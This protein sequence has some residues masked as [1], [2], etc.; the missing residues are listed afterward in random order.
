MILNFSLT[1]NWGMIID[2][3]EEKDMLNVIIKTVKNYKVMEAVI[4]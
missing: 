2:I 3:V 1:K 4:L